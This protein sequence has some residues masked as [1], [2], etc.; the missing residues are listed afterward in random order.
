MSC[1]MPKSVCRRTGRNPAIFLPRS[2]HRIH[3]IGCR[4]VRTGEL[5]AWRETGSAQAAANRLDDSAREP[6][7]LRALNGWKMEPAVQSTLLAVYW[8]FYWRIAAARVRS[9][10]EKRKKNGK[11]ER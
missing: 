5:A 10:R 4:R 7:R 8:P 3:R 6:A 9:N 1:Q 11:K 2:I